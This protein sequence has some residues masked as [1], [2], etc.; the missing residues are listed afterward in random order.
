MYIIYPRDGSEG[1]RGVTFNC[2]IYLL[3]LFVILTS[4]D[5]IYHM[6]SYDS[7]CIKK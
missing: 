1:P 3:Y 7:L 6:C 5:K 2:Y 4:G